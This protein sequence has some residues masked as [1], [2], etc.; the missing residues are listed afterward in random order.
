M[1]RK[2]TTLEGG[3]AERKYRPEVQSGSTDRKWR[4]VEVKGHPE[5]Q[6]SWLND[7][8]NP[9]GISKNPTESWKNP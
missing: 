9:L 7:P 3:S 8:E 1:D 4:V 6:L 2:E 5:W